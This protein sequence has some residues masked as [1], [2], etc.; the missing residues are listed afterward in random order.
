MITEKT[1]EKICPAVRKFWHLDFHSESSNLV[2]ETEKSVRYVQNVNKVVPPKM[3]KQLPPTGRKELNERP[4]TH[5][6]LTCTPG[7]GGKQR[8]VRTTAAGS[9]L[10]T[11]HNSTQGFSTPIHSVE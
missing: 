6:P 4:R 8:Q 11:F 2:S 7:L 3:N 5:L 9:Q 1:Q 10:A